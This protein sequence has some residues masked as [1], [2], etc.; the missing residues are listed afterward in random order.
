MISRFDHVFVIG[1]GGT[2]SHLVGPLL[3]LLKF[4]PHGT[5]NVTLIDG[6]SYEEKNANRQVFDVEHLGENKA[7]ATAQ[8]LGHTNVRTIGQYVDREKFSKILDKFVNKDDR[9]LV[10]TAVD[11]HASRKAI[12]NCLDQDGYQNF[13][14]ISPGNAYDKGQVVLY[15]MEDGEKRTVHPFDKYPDIAN[16]DGFV[17]TGQGCAAQAPSTPQLITANMAAAWGTLL[18][19]SNILD[20]RGWYEEIHFDCRRA[21]VAPQGVLRD[22]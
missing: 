21:K 12:I 8:R 5:S 18:T 15:V 1:V 20:E 17:P 22:G 11:N 3:Q 4:H 9:L 14:L 2:G 7:R 6:D 16:P 13:V 19:V 10:I